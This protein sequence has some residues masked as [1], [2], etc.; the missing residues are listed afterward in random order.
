[1]FDL[2]NGI[3]WPAALLALLVARA[4]VGAPVEERFLQNWPA[5][6]GPLA[7]GV[8]PQADPP[9]G[10]V[11]LKADKIPRPKQTVYIALF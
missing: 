4:A 10:E 1:M 7:T 6:R 3:R 2:K 11:S 9:A 8:A 5:W